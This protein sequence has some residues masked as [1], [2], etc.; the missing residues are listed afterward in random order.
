[1]Q[2]SRS[3]GFSVSIRVCGSTGAHTHKDRKPNGL[4][5]ASL[6]HQAF[7]DAR[8]VKLGLYQD[9]DLFPLIHVFVAFGN[10][11]EWDGFRK[12]S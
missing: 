12:H 9:F 10:V 2:K 11:G 5:S 3:I 1:M 8:F 6:N 7:S 4:S